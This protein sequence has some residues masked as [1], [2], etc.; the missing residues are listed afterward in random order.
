M[1]LPGE[2]VFRKNDF[3]HEIPETINKYLHLKRKKGH[4]EYHEEE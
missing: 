4:F 1:D 3:F 2:L